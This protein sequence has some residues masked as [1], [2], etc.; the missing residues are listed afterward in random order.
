M[1]FFLLVFQLMWS[2]SFGQ[3][4]FAV[5]DY[6]SIHV[7]IKEMYIEGQADYGVPEK[8]YELIETKCLAKVQNEMQWAQIRSNGGCMSTRELQLLENYIR[9][10]QGEFLFFEE[11][12]EKLKTIRTDKL[13]QFATQFSQKIFRK[14]V[15][16]NNVHFVLDSN[17]VLYMDN[18]VNDLTG[19]A[20]IEVL[21]YNNLI[22]DKIFDD[23]A[24]NLIDNI[25]KR[26]EDF[27]EMDYETYKEKFPLEEK[28]VQNSN[29]N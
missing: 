3:T 6:D 23:E 29:N 9:Y 27:L 7:V 18:E 21:N 12:Y 17:E 14:Q 1:L 28:K 15:T 16:Q 22:T 13:N 25:Y 8:L 11:G 24:M 4:K 20:I 10:Q 26:M 2:N 5:A 19:A